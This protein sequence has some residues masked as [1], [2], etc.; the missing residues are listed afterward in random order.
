MVGLWFAAFAVSR[1]PS[2]DGDLP[3]RIGS[4]DL[5]IWVIV[6]L[7]QSI[8]YAAS[9]IVSLVSA[10]DLPGGWLGEAGAEAQ[11]ADDAVE[12]AVE[13]EAEAQPDEGLALEKRAA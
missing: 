12:L 7:I 11:S 1:I 4:P 9:V 10:L 5:S 3:G 8:P 2:F 13:S 6:L